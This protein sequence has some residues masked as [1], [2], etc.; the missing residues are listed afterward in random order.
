MTARLWLRP[1]VAALLASAAC[2]ESGH[3]YVVILPEAPGLREGSAV[4]YLGVLVGEVTR[5][6]FLRD[7]VGSPRVALDLRLSR[8]SVPL[9]ARDSVRIRNLGLLGDQVLS[10]VPGPSNVAILGSGDTLVAAENAIPPRIEP[11]EF[12]KA[13]ARQAPDSVAGHG[14]DTGGARRPAPRP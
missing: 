5:I 3:E 2:R 8:D 1:V 14:A 6:T 12:L 9:R 10:I 7:T 4:E 13:L 11:D